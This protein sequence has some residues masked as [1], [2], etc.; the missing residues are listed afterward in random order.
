MKLKNN[1]ITSNLHYL[2]VNFNLYNQIILSNYYKNLTGLIARHFLSL[3]TNTFDKEKE[4]MEIY[5]RRNSQLKI[6]AF[7]SNMKN[8]VHYKSRRLSTETIET[9]TTTYNKF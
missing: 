6:A 4:R 8:N 9:L 2:L 7:E 1:S 5:I 3:H